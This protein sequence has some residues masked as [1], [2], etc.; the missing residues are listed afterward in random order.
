MPDVRPAVC[1]TCVA[2]KQNGE[3][4][5]KRGKVVKGKGAMLLQYE[6]LEHWGYSRPST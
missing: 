3:E 4:D 6:A 5:C 1:V 2:I